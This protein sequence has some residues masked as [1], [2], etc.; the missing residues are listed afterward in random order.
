MA[1]FLRVFWSIL[2][3]LFVVLVANGALTYLIGVLDH[4]WLEGTASS[5]RVRR[6]LSFLPAA[7]IFMVL[8]EQTR[9]TRNILFEQRSHMTSVQWRQIYFALSGCAFLVVLLCSVSMMIFSIDIWLAVQRL[10][11]LPVFF[12]FCIVLAARQA[13][14]GLNISKITG[15]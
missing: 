13:N 5:A 7:I 11:P 4:M 2:W 9:G 10:L 14:A 6:G 3:R 12:L 8:A 1:T 15:A